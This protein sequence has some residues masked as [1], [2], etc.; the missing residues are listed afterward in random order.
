MNPNSKSSKRAIPVE[1]V[2][3]RESFEAPVDRH[4][5]GSA[6]HRAKDIDTY[7]VVRMV[8]DCQESLVR[9]SQEFYVSDTNRTRK[10][11]WTN[12]LFDRKDGVFWQATLKSS[13]YNSAYAVE[14][15]YTVVVTA[16][17]P[18]IAAREIEYLKTK[19]GVLPQEQGPA[20]HILRDKHGLPARVAIDEKHAI[21]HEDLAMH[22]G[23]SIVRWSDR[24]MQGL[25]EPGL[26]LFRGKP[27]TGKTSFLRYMVAKLWKTHRFY[28]VPPDSF[29]LLG[30]SLLAEVLMKE[31][32]VFP[33]AVKVIVIE[34]AE[35][36][37][38]DRSDENA[39]DVSS[40]L[41]LTDGFIGDLVNVHVV[42]TIN[43]ETDDLDKAI[44]RPG[45]QRF[46]RE[47]ELLSYENATQLAAHLGVTLT[48]RRAYSIAEIYHQRDLARGEGELLKAKESKPIGFGSAN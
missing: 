1:S 11:I 25:A 28:Y 16:P 45:R 5:N 38:L 40:L 3:E 29:G 35:R 41:N 30:S 31:Q 20:F 44:L 48:E 36:L 17:S 14:S 18:V 13:S 22:Y 6:Y 4:Y 10:L 2:K 32:R 12:L 15:T 9:S 42:C 23:N 19:Y 7:D 33:Q 26:S 47:F 34:D 46:F 21:S 37:L 27:G 24:F 43:C 39:R 8:D